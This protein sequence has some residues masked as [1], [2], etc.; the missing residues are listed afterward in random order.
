MH[1]LLVG[2][3][4]IAYLLKT[5]WGFIPYPNTGS[6]SLPVTNLITFANVTD[7]PLPAVMKIKVF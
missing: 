5:I 6:A 1:M 7:P 4:D 2:S 3:Y